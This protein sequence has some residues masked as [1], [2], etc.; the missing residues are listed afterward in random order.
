LLGEL[1]HRFHRDFRIDPGINRD[2][3]ILAIGG[4]VYNSRLSEPSLALQ[5][6]SFVGTLFPLTKSSVTRGGA[7]SLLDGSRGG[8]VETDL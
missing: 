3:E 8:G 1:S 5:N 7:F 2:R 4:A 6:Q